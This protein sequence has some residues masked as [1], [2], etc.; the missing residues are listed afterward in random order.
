[1]AVYVTCP[2]CKE[3]IPFGRLFCTFCGAKLELTQETVTN[4]V[5]GKEFFTDAQ[6]AELDRARAAIQRREYR[7][8]DA[9][10][11]GLL[12][13]NIHKLQYETVTDRELAGSI[14]VL[15]T[16]NGLPPCEW[17]KNLPPT[18][19]RLVVNDLKGRI[20]RFPTDFSSNT[21]IPP[22]KPDH[23]NRKPE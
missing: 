21:M 6:I 16:F 19:E 20:Y 10:G 5:T 3:R 17:E 4:R 12:R 2:Q 11:K 14:V 23:S 7:D 22:S 13:R 18:V 8:R 15:G 1:M 9:S